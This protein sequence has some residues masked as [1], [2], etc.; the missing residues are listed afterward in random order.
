MIEIDRLQLPYPVYFNGKLIA[1]I[2]S[3]VYTDVWE[4][5]YVGHVDGELISGTL[6]EVQAKLTKVFCH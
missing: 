2:K 5:T 3:A 1:Y 4:I 6:D